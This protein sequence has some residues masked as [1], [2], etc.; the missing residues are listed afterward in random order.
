[1]T[2]SADLEPDDLPGAFSSMWRLFKLGYQHEPRLLTTA[3]VL[4]LLSALPDAMVALWLALLGKGVVQDDNRLVMV[5]AIGLGVSAT[6]TWLLRVISTRLQRR[7]RDKVTI[8]LEGHVAGLQARVVTVAHQE[9]P[10][11][12]D[13]LS[14]VRDQIYVLDH[15]YMS[16]FSTCGWILR[17][18]VTIG[19]LVSIHWSLALLVLAALPTV[20]ASGWRP[21]V[22]RRVQEEVAP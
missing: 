15:L 6:L 20:A 10:D 8:A 11:Y 3:F 5:A 21:G 1:M 22:E 14:V 12:L 18:G 17:L 16:V 13:R 2:S 4:S 19:L 7:F 9:R